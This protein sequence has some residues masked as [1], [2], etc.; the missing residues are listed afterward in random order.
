M[1][2]I[3]NK[4]SLFLFLLT[5][6]CGIND[7]KNA[8]TETQKVKIDNFIRSNENKEIELPC[9]LSKIK[10][11][12]AQC[13][14]K[15]I[16][17]SKHKE[18]ME[19]EIILIDNELRKIKNSKPSFD[20]K[21]ELA[22]QNHNKN[23][24]ILSDLENKNKEYQ[25]TI[26]K[27]EQLINE[28]KELIK[29]INDKKDDYDKCENNL[30]QLNQEAITAKKIINQLKDEKEKRKKEW[31]ILK[32]FRKILEYFGYRETD[33]DINK[34][35][36]EQKKIN[37]EKNIKK[38]L[39]NHQNSEFKKAY[40]E[41]NKIL[42]AIKIN[43]NKQADIDELKKSIDGNNL[44][45]EKKQSQ[46]KSYEAYIKAEE[47]RE[48]LIKQKINLY[49]YKQS[50][51]S[52][53]IKNKKYHEIL[54]KKLLKK[55]KEDKCIEF[56]G[57]KCKV[58]EGK[59]NSIIIEAA[60]IFENR[61]QRF[62]KKRITAKSLK[63]QQIKFFNKIE[64]QKLKNP[65][66]IWKASKP[67]KENNKTEH[68]KE[69]KNK[70]IHTNLSYNN[71]L[72][73]NNEI[74]EEKNSKEEYEQ[75][76]R[77]FIDDK[78]NLRFFNLG[79]NKVIENIIK[80][81]NSKRMPL[82]L[83]SSIMVKMCVVMMSN[84]ESEK[85]KLKNNQILINALDKFYF[86]K[87]ISEYD[88]LSK[89]IKSNSKEIVESISDLYRTNLEVF[90]FF[91]LIG[92]INLVNKSKS[93]KSTKSIYKNLSNKLISTGRYQPVKLKYLHVYSN[94][95]ETDASFLSIKN[96]DDTKKNALIILPYYDWGF[97]IYNNFK[98]I[99]NM[100]LYLRYNV[101][102]IQIKELKDIEQKLQY[103]KNNNIKLDLI[104]LNGHGNPTGIE[105]SKE[106]NISV[107][108]KKDINKLK[109]I[110]D[111]HIKDST[112]WILNSC[113]TGGKMNGA[114]L[115]IAK[116][117]ALNITKPGNSLQCFIKGDSIKGAI[118]DK[119]DV[120]KIFNDHGVDIYIN[121]GTY[122]DIKKF[123]SD[124]F[125]KGYSIKDYKEDNFIERSK[126]QKN[127][128]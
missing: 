119:N 126:I 19:K 113:S 56:D 39:L 23:I 32:P 17:I 9:Q 61:N 29:Y 57:V 7:K 80:L 52:I 63:L 42:A 69:K 101:K 73:E 106:N 114:K 2:N 62:R 45:I 8:L 111:P 72:F 68:K 124:K 66:K 1:K 30:I 88:Y 6:S 33:E 43:I 4:L 100:Q 46:I 59:E 31:R 118:F 116:F 44:Q 20:E 83:M 81:I 92:N 104:V 64:L 71:L 82:D 110:F 91:G 11:E 97:Q 26:V 86:N 60:D 98:N 112:H 96:F 50:L 51:N 3:I 18:S 117:L 38:T 87:K 79:D 13:S 25:N 94:N 27:N 102:I 16:K 70:L 41:K 77:H 58:E 107:F 28:E 121:R 105:I 75:I 47:E 78:Y 76:L 123:N 127:K 36:E 90:L 35:L 14:E 48:K 24:E 10:S 49:N 55:A 125:E 74:T 95:K 109:L 85:E 65:E 108:C 40:E 34:Q 15:Q 115:N 37:E 93:T 128:N 103:Y 12:L 89:N 53:E 22:R 84:N 120:P 21:P 99:F 54:G 122:L 67:K 5:L